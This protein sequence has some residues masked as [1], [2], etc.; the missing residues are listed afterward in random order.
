MASPDSSGTM[1]FSALDTKARDNFDKKLAKVHHSVLPPDITVEDVYDNDGAPL[2]IPNIPNHL[3]LDFFFR[4]FNDIA[5]DNYRAHS[6]KSLDV[7][8]TIWYYEV[9]NTHCLTNRV[10]V[11]RYNIVPM[12]FIVIAKKLNIDTSSWCEP[13]SEAFCSAYMEAWLAKTCGL[14]EQEHSCQEKLVQTFMDSGFGLCYFPDRARKDMMKAMWN[15]GQMVSEWTIIKPENLYEAVLSGEISRDIFEMEGPMLVLH[16]VFAQAKKEK[17]RKEEDEVVAMAMNMNIEDTVDYY[18]DTNPVRMDRGL[19]A[20]LLVDIE[21]GVVEMSL[22]N[23]N[24]KP[25]ISVAQALN[26][27]QEVKEDFLT[28]LMGRTTLGRE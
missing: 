12:A 22:P 28:E 23:E 16:W 15:L 18:I 11:V 5:R 9:S 8:R 14:G 26:I 7:N 21:P 19:V 10:D 27:V 20:D 25:W 17:E 24:R 6:S 2:Y 1:D 4:N 13:G 3:Q